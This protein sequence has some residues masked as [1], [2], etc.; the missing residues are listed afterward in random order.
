[1]KTWR[2][3]ARN[4]SRSKKFR[5]NKLRLMRRKMRTS[6]YKSTKPYYQ[7]C[8]NSLAYMPYTRRWR[9]PWF[10]SWSV[11]RATAYWS[12]VP[13]WRNKAWNLPVRWSQS[14]NMPTIQ[15]EGLLIWVHPNRSKKSC[16]INKI[17]QYW[18][19]R[20]QDSLQPTNRYCKIWRWIT[21]YPDWSLNTAA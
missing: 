21:N 1:M 6:P 5:W 20:R 17:C 15:Q 2:V 10:L 19:K 16:S 14:S 13:C 4:K 12:T 11:S 7:N 3:R 9:F 18:K 8:N